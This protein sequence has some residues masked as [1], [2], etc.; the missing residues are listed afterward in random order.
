MK[1]VYPAVFSPLEQHN[2]YCVTFPDLP[3]A[4]TEGDTLAQALEMAVDCASL[5]V[6]DEL[7][8][9]N[10]APKATAPSD[11]TLENKEDFI[12]LVVLDMDEYAE[13]YG[14]KAI[15]KNCTIPAWL[16]T[17]SEKEHINFSAVLQE[18]LIEKL[19]INK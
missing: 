3:G 9:G 2:G 12:N 17:L 11:I 14:Q 6:L 13:K 15:R 19:G 1:L 16:N 7:E 5:W 10:S 8:N 18:A 4:V